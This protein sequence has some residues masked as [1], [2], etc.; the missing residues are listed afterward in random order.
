MRIIP[1]EWLAGV[2]I[3]EMGTHFPSRRCL[4]RTGWL[5]RSYLN[6]GMDVVV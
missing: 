3:Y 5:G 4:E 2:S 6:H 1:N